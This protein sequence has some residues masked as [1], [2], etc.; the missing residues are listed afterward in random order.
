MAPS[1]KLQH[2]I[3][4]LVLFSYGSYVLSDRFGNHNDRRA[5]IDEK[6][7]KKGQEEGG[8]IAKVETF[9]TKNR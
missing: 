4:L 5:E 8:S 1:R 6:K 3:P 9:G 7:R 2:A